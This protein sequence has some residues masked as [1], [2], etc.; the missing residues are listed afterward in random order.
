MSYSGLKQQAR[1]ACVPWFA[2][3]L[4]HYY[5]HVQLVVF[6]YVLL[7]PLVILAVLACHGHALVLIVVVV[8]Q[9]LTKKC[10]RRTRFISVTTP[11]LR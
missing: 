9:L 11:R 4:V 6:V 1:A 2:T 3:I 10:M 8:P 5:A 7:A